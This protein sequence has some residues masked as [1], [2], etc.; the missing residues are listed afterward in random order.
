MVSD[1]NSA[2]LDW[3]G[4]DY[5]IGYDAFEF[6]SVV[7]NTVGISPNTL[8]MLRQE[9]CQQCSGLSVCV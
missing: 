3:T 8:R 9:K 6:D 5:T 7:Q 4:V 2:Y 1:L